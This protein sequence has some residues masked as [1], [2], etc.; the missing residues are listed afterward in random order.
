MIQ[1]GIITIN[2]KVIEGAT[3][4]VPDENGNLIDATVDIPIG[5]GIV[6]PK[7]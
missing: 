1:P 5:A 2:R 7:K 3:L 4:A 6:V